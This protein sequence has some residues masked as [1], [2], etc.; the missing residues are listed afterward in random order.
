MR[1]NPVV[2]E[3]IRGPRKVHQHTRKKDPG[4]WVLLVLDIRLY[5]VIRFETG[6]APCAKGVDVMDMWVRRIDT[7]PFSG[8]L[9]EVGAEKG[10]EKKMLGRWQLACSIDVKCQCQERYTLVR[11][12]EDL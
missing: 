8:V 2:L 4:G 5:P 10:D 11:L 6:E 12:G 1:E 7:V 9:G 3:K